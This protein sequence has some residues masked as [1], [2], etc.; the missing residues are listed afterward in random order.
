MGDAV[1]GDTPMRATPR[2]LSGD[3]VRLVE[4]TTIRSDVGPATSKQRRGAT[5]HMQTP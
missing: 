3:G 2:R 5:R 1:F 4:G